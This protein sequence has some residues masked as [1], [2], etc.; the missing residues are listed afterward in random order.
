MPDTTMTS[1]SESFNWPDSLSSQ[2]R[3]HMTGP[4]SV[5]C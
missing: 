4:A 1:Q 3:V 2:S 5:E